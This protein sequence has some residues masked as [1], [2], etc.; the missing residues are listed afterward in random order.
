MAEIGLSSPGP[1][2]NDDVSFLGVPSVGVLGCSQVKPSDCNS[3]EAVCHTFIL[4]ASP[5]FSFSDKP[6]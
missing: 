1:G 6:A 3:G 5:G 2:R 4:Q